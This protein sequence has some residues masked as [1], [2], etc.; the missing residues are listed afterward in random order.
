MK[1][2]IIPLFIVFLSLSVQA[3][4]SGFG[5]G[6]MVGEPTGLSAKM[7]TSQTTAAQFG[8]AWSFDSYLHA[9]ADFIMHK[10]DLINVSKGELPIYFGLGAPTA[11]RR[12]RAPGACASRRAA[13]RSARSRATCTRR[14]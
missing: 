12:R 3:Q 6:V 1:K 10:F 11:G 14:A 4:D 8:L 5:V 9:H 7:W 13:R 2:L